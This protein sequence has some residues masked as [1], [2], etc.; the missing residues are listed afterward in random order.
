MSGQQFSGA[1]T[2]LAAQ[3]APE[4]LAFEISAHL[5]LASDLQSVVVPVR[6]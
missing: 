5:L 2:E 4:K 6:N 1:E 3:L